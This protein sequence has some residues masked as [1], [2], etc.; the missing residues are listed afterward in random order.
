MPL[1]Q[2]SKRQIRDHNLRQRYGI[3]LQQWEVAYDVQ[4]GN[5]ANPRCRNKLTDVDHDHKTG[6]FRGLLCN[7]CNRA[8]GALNDDLDRLLGLIEYLTDWQERKAA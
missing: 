2:R 7:E 3:T 4:D 1:S 6:E 5:C 8:L